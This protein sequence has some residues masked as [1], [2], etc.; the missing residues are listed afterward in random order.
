M[1]GKTKNKQGVTMK[2]VTLKQKCTTISA[3]RYA[4][5]KARKHAFHRNPSVN[6]SFDVNELKKEIRDIV[7]DKNLTCRAYLSEKDAYEYI[8]RNSWISI[9]KRIQ[10]MHLE[11]ITDSKSLKSVCEMTGILI[12]GTALHLNTEAK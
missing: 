8:I 6:I 7:K 4:L 10:S 3:F 9:N 12:Y 1:K 2:T 5:Y 11:D